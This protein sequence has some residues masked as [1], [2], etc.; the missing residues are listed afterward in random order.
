M[1]VVSCED[2]CEPFIPAWFWE[3]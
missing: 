2:N 3:I 1:T